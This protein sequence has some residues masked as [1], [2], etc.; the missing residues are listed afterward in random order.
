MRWRFEPFIATVF[1]VAGLM[2]AAGPSRAQQYVMKFTTQT[3]ND[4][5]HEFIKMYKQELEKATNNRIR[6]DIFP[7]S[8]L[9]GAQRQTE[10]LRLG[11]IEAAIGPSELFVGADPRFGGLAMAGLFKD[12]QHTRRAMLVPEVRKAIFDVAASR[13]LL[14]IGINVYDLQSF[15]FKT[16]VAKLQDFAGKRIRVL[17][18]E[19]E[20]ASINA[21]GGAAVPMSLQEVAP[22]LQQGTID[23]VN[24]VLSVFVAFKYNDAAPNLLNTHL[25]PLVTISLVSK[26]W[27]DRLP[28]DL[29][30]A[31]VEAGAKVEPEINKWQ[32][33]R[34]EADMSAWT[35]RG[36]KVVQ[37][38][39][40]EQEEAVR[41]VTAAI[42]PILDTNAPLKEFYG[43]VKAGAATVN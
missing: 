11:T 29:Q 23:G 39:P 30:K 12:I 19:S 6:V 32:I 31:V 22:A 7:A 20:E 14:V 10:G 4:I 27:Y 41:R 25:W 28:P 15:V 37:L 3:I 35:S 34:L 18:S 42:Q 16:P 40:A 43:K 38:S 26:V 1:I 33:V 13:N 9:G 5:Q 8:Q 17:A 24:S 21:L 36:G 2:P